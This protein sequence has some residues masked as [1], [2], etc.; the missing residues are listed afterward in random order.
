MKHSE[1]MKYKISKLMKE[2]NTET[3]IP[4]PVGFQGLKPY[5]ENH[6]MFM[7]GQIRSTM[8]SWVLYFNRLGKHFEERGNQ[9]RADRHYDQA[10]AFETFLGEEIEKGCE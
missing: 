4:T 1:E 8:E 10:I 2:K 5:G 3:D 6:D 9:E 7:V